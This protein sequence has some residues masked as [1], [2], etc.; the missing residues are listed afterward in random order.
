[1]HD[2][3]ILLCDLATLEH[4]EVI[5]FG[6]SGWRSPHFTPNGASL[7]GVKTTTADQ[8]ER[9]DISTGAETFIAFTSYVDFSPLP[10]ISVAR[11]QD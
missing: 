1:V 6:A 3:A 5:P 8:I 4:T 7:I 9:V 11:D 2:L 10:P